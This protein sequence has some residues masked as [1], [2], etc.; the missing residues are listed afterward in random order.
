MREYLNKETMEIFDKAI[1]EAIQN[2]KILKLSYREWNSYYNLL[3]KTLYMQIP[4]VNY[5]EFANSLIT[6]TVMF[7]TEDVEKSYNDKL[8]RLKKNVIFAQE[9]AENSNRGINFELFNVISLDG[10]IK[11]LSDFIKR[12]IETRK[13]AYKGKDGNDYY[14]L[15]SLMIANQNYMKYR[16]PLIEKTSKNIF[17][18]KIDTNKYYR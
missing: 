18:E 15:E 9:I 6:A 1:K 13:V 7:E 8:K 11:E 4:T 3:I 16:N 17:I 5:H 10:A 2:I 14:D 12:D